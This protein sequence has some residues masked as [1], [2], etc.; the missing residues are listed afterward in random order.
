MA[1]ATE[2]TVFVHKWEDDGH[3]NAPFRFV[4]LISIPSTEL[5]ETNCEGYNNAMRMAHLEAR[6]FG[7]DSL[8]SCDV[9]G[10]GIHHH[11][12]IRDATGK[13]FKVGCDC[14]AR[15]N[16]T[17]LMTATANA[18][19][20]RLK[21]IRNA[22]RQAEWEAARARTAA[23]LQAE[24]DANGGLTNAE[25]A[26]KAREKEAELLKAKYA[27][28]N[29]WLIRMIDG[30]SGEFVSS[31]VR[32]LESKSLA[33]LSDR[34]IEILSDIFSRTHGRRNSKAYADALVVFYSHLPNDE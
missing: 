2:P 18:E 3:G 11:C 9:C 12:V 32:H 10:T 1:T 22:K 5:A 26:A 14:V 28:E 16:D 30:Q 34:C 4:T 20:L 21:E 15:T 27:A 24:R 31:M 19:R 29:E 8:G 6:Q 13:H 7:I 17:K 23:L 25:V 33:S